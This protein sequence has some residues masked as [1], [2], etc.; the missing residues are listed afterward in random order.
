MLPGDPLSLCS[1][2]DLDRFALAQ[3]DDRLLPA[4]LAAA[5]HPAPLRLRLHLEDVDRLDVDVEELL[6]R[7]ADLRLVRVRVH[8]ERVLALLDQRVA[9]LR[10]DGGEQD[11]V[12]VQ[13]HSEAFLWTSS[14]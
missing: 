8:A 2:E 1:F 7:L 12:W 13:A 10:D 11:F 4:G 14:S 5:N 9:L 6:D 3:L